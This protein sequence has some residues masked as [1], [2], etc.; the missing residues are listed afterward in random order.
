M[1]RFVLAALAAALFVLAAR[2]HLVDESIAVPNEAGGR[3]EAEAGLGARSNQGKHLAVG[4]R[5]GGS[6]KV[7]KHF[8][9]ERVKSNE[10]FRSSIREEE[11]FSS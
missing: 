9:L 6:P 8:V 7:V 5:S 1:K 10:F 11:I 3:L 2:P 4:Q